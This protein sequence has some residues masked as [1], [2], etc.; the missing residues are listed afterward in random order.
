VS[1]Q[2]LSEDE[3]YLRRTILEY[4]LEHPDAKDSARW[5]EEWWAPKAAARLNEGEIQRVFQ[6]LVERGWLKVREVTPAQSRLLVKHEV[7]PSQVI[8][9][10]EKEKV[11]EIKAFLGHDA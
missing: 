10:V 4:L 2:G 8:Y 5:I 11:E 1:K 3:A 6:D 9:G 7:T